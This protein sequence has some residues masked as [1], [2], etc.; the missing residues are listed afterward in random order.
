MLAL[1]VVLLVGGEAGLLA[2]HLVLSFSEP[3]LH[4]KLLEL[5]PLADHLF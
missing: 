5:V 4:L 1:C 2:D 3:D